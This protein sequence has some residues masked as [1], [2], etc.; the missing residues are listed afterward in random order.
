M[1]RAPEPIDPCL[2]GHPDG[3][4][5]FILLTAFPALRYG[6]LGKQG[7]EDRDMAL[8]L[9]ARLTGAAIALLAFAVLTETRAQDA[10]PTPSSPQ[11]ATTSAPAPAPSGQK[12]GARVRGESST[13]ASPAVAE[14]HRLPPDSTTK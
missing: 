1:L 10:T 12:G 5:T 9:T 6:T 3:F 13:P 2:S 7:R 11:S 4:K 14:Q 8:R